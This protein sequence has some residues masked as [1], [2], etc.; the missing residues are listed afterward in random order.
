MDLPDLRKAAYLAKVTP[1]IRPARI[2]GSDGTSLRLSE[3]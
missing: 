3:S 2:N 1:E